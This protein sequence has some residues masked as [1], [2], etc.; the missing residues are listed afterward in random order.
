MS[1]IRNILNK[2]HLLVNNSLPVTSG[3][4][5]GSSQITISSTTGFTDYSSSVDSR[6]LTEKGR[7]DTILLASS[8]D[9]DSFA[10]I[11]TLINS[12][13]TTND[14]AFASF[15]TG[16]NNRLNNLETTSGSVNTSISNLNTFSASIET[17][18]STLATYTSSINTQISNLN[19]ATSSYEINGRGI[20]SGSSQISYTGLSNIPSGI[21]SGSS[22]LVELQNLALAY[23]IAL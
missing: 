8:A 18:N 3:T 17:K 21:V 11:V 20:V 15:Y 16:S 5:S 1:I 22:Q 12:V 14:T 6:I 10:E 19:S 2:T 4:V 23:A 7:I 13:D 9:K